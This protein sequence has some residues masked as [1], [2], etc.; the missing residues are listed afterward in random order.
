MFWMVDRFC[1]YHALTILLSNQRKLLDPPR[2]SFC[3][4]KTLKQVECSSD[5]WNNF[6]VHAVQIT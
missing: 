4:I 1:L 3:R 6:P 5:G 2:V